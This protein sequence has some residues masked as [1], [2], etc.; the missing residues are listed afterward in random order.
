MSLGGKK[1]PY[2]NGHLA[3][4]YTLFD[5]ELGGENLEGRVRNPD[6][7]RLTDDGSISGG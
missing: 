3:H 5:A 1:G 2:I 7:L 4:M 6:D